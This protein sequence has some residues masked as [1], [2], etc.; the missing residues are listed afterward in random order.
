M[1][2][3]PVPGVQGYALQGRAQRE[4]GHMT[5]DTLIDS[6]GAGLAFVAIVAVMAV[7]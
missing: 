2:S 6:I 1:D 4:G 7:V 5:R 3:H